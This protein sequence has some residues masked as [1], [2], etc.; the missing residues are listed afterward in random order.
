MNNSSLERQIITLK[1]RVRQLEAALRQQD[2]RLEIVFGLTETLSNFFGLLLVKEY[3]SRDLAQYEMN[4]VADAQV[5]VW[6]LRQRLKPYGIVIHTRQGVGWYIDDETKRRVEAI[7]TRDPIGVINGEGQ[8]EDPTADATVGSGEATAGDTDDAVGTSE[9]EADDE[10]AAVAG[11]AQGSPEEGG[12]SE[13]QP[14][15][16]HG[17]RTIEVGTERPLRR[18]SPAAEEYGSEPAEEDGGSGAKI[19]AVEDDA[20]TASG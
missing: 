2:R 4:V 15:A 10:D 16:G 14:D 11:E 7:M 3:V 9:A 18:G 1:A 5:T 6:R 19:G 8:G 13:H 12:H 17:Y 20:G